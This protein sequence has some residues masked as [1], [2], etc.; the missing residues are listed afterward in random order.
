[1]PFL[2]VSSARAI[3]DISQDAHAAGRHVYVAAMGEELK[4]VL[5]SLQAD[6][7]FDHDKLFP[8]RKEALEAAVEHVR[9]VESES[10]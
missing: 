3:A 4:K 10:G 9:R 5:R 2:D 1:M 7:Y 8:S 6:K